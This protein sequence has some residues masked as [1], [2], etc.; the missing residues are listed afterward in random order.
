MRLLIVGAGASYSEGQH[1]GLPEELCPPL[2]RNFARRLWS[3]YNPH[4]LLTAYLKEQ[5]D[6]PGDDPRELFLHLELDDTARVNVER[7]FEFAWKNRNKYAGEWENL[8]YHGILNPLVFLL[9]QGLWE[10]GPMGQP[11]VVAQ[12]VA[13]HLKAGD[14]VINLNYDTIFEVGAVQVGHDLVFL[15]NKPE[16]SK[17]MISKPHGS[18]NL[19]VDL[20]RN[21]FAFG[22]LDW[23]GLP[24]P[25]NGRRNYPGFVPP[26]YNK[27]YAQ[28]PVAYTI[29]EASRFLS[30]RMLTF[31]GVGLTDSDSDLLELYRR[32]CSEAE[33]VEFINPNIAAAE[34]ARALLGVPISHFFRIEEWEADITG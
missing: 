23:P 33:R 28:H 26:R 7:F 4:V 10:K 29:V 22:K 27:S 9:S 6:N 19:I 12:S 24:Q 13:K 25:S 31:W 3:D 16:S 15:P 17:L 18:I 21:S 2:I 1:A 8:L 20:E 14:G 5:G 32:W 30:P 11:M 34:R